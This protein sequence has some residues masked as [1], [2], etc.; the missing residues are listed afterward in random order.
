AHRRRGRGRGGA[1]A[2]LVAARAAL[3]D[4]RVRQVRRPGHVGVGRSGDATVGSGPLQIDPA[5]LPFWY[6]TE[7]LTLP[8]VPAPSGHG[9]PAA[10]GDEP[11]LVGLRPGEAPPWP[12][13]PV[14][15]Q[16]GTRWVAHHYVYLG[17]F[18]HG[19][20]VAEM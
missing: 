3:P 14:E 9:L 4:R 19:D 8:R 17:L 7:V 5:V 16:R 2:R 18:A 1:A 15:D 20:A 11:G 12:V 13:Q 6:E 10:P